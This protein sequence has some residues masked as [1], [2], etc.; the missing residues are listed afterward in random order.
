MNPAE[1]ELDPSRIQLDDP[2]RC[3]VPDDQE[4]A[5]LA[6][7]LRARGQVEPIIVRPLGDGRFE[8]VDGRRRV[9]L[10][11]AIMATP[12]TSGAC[13][14]EVRAIVRHVTPLDAAVARLSAADFAGR[15]CALEAA[16]EVASTYHLAAQQDS[17]LTMRD[18]GTSISRAFG[19]VSEQIRIAKVVTPTL[20]RE[21]GAEREGGTIDAVVRKLTHATL[22]RIAKRKETGDGSGAAALLR[23]A[24]AQASE[25][26][27]KRGPR[28]RPDTPEAAANSATSTATEN[29]PG[30]GAGDAQVGVPPASAGSALRDGASIASV[31]SETT[32]MVVAC[33]AI[34]RSTTR[35]AY[36]E[37]PSGAALVIGD[38]VESLDSVGCDQLSAAIDALHERLAARRSE[39]LAAG[40]S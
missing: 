31:S 7:D 28:H 18:F 9:R 36:I 40:T 12:E 10:H 24:L 14:P 6:E 17:N 34:V 20:L 4:D 29:A 27:T 22:L 33:A 38:R 1:V 19:T 23:T 21:A 32:R 30:V 11:T 15:L 39:L 25:P 13:Q 16:H 37:A 5:R 2:A 3:V 35:I 26:V 8:I